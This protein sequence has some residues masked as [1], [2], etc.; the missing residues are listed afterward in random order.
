M[1][2][3]PPDKPGAKNDLKDILEDAVRDAMDDRKATVMPSV[4][5]GVLRKPRRI[6]T[7]SSCPAMAFTTST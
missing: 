4:P 1:V 2:E 7:S 3:V 5:S 6:N